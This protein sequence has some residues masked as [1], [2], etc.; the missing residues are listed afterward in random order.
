MARYETSLIGFNLIKAFEGFRAKAVPLADGRWV[1]GYG[2]TVSTRKGTQ[3]NKNDA[4]DL[5][6]WDVKKLE[7]PLCDLIYTPL[8]QNQF[9]ALMSLVFNIGLT[10]FETST[11]LRRLNEG[12]PVDASA[13]FDAWRRAALGGE[14]IIVDALVRR[15]AAEKALFLTASRDSVIAPTPQLPPLCDTQMAQPGQE[16]PMK[17]VF[18]LQGNGKTIV[19]SAV[20]PVQQDEPAISKSE[21]ISGQDEKGLIS[22]DDALGAEE[23]SSN[24]PASETP[25]QANKDSDDV[26]PPTETSSP[27]VEAAEK[28]AGRMSSVASKETPTDEED[29]FQLQYTDQIAETP[30]EQNNAKSSAEDTPP[31]VDEEGLLLEPYEPTPSDN[32]QDET[33]IPFDYDEPVYNDPGMDPQ[34]LLTDAQVVPEDND[35][36]PAY[37]RGRFVFISMGIIGIAMTLGGLWQMQN[38][39]AITS[40]LDL[41]KGPGQ[42]FLGVILMVVGAY[43]LLRRLNR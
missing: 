15:R 13:G 26:E 19:Q 7:A 10:N 14:I 17:V 23:L 3:I 35:F 20:V 28:I 27:I 24:T 40:N 29:V 43:Y 33:T 12:C 41:A 39:A 6:T 42:T 22:L 8:S 18:D 5:L 32:A 25:D 36:Q 16:T 30:A 34:T 21:E 31:L 9:D 11:V 38:S 37:D 4:S 2:H 1:V